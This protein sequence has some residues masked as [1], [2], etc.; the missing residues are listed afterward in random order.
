MPTTASSR[1]PGKF[2]AA[3]SP[4]STPISSMLS[5][6]TDTIARVKAQV[7]FEDGRTAIVDAD[8]AIREAQRFGFEERRL[9]KAS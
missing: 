8:L 1:V 5:I 2:A 9:R 4:R 3:S 6:P 7:T